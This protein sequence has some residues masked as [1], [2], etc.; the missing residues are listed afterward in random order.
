MRDRQPR[1][2][3]RLIAKLGK[4]VLIAAAVAIA[5]G[6]ALIVSALV[7]LQT[8]V[9]RRYACAR[10]EELANDVLQGTMQLGRCSALG[11]RQLRIDG[12]SMHD[13]TGRQVLEV[14]TV[15]AT[16][17]LKALLR[18]EL[19]ID[20]AHLDA[21]TLRL[22]G[23][24]EAELGIT[25]AFSPVA[26]VEP[27]E[28]RGSTS[29]GV[30]VES[31]EVKD[32]SA[33]GLPGGLIARDVDGIAALAL[34]DSFTLTIQ[35]LSGRIADDEGRS[36]HLVGAAG[37]LR[38]DKDVRSELSL[39]LETSDSGRVAA[40]GDYAQ[41]ALAAEVEVSDV[42]IASVPVLGRSR[43]TL[44]GRLEVLAAF[45]A[46][47]SDPG[48]LDTID[49]FAAFEARQLS[50]QGLEARVVRLGAEVQGALPSPRVRV[51]LAAEGVEA[52]DARFERMNLEATGRGGRYRVE[53]RVPFANGVFADLELTTRINPKLWLVDG[54]VRMRGAAVSPLVA[55]L[56][57]IKLR[58]REGRAAG[59]VV[60][61]GRGIHMQARGRYDAGSESRLRAVVREL[62]LAELGPALGLDPSLQGT[63]TGTLHFRG[64]LDQPKLDAQL[65]LSDGALGS[66][67]PA[68]C[69]FEATLQ[70]D[71]LQANL[72]L[73]LPA[74][75]ST[76][77]SAEV[78]DVS[79]RARLDD[80]THLEVRAGHGESPTRET[81]R[82]TADFAAPWVAWVR[83]GL[84]RD[85]PSMRIEGDVTDLKL[86][87]LPG[88]CDRF[89]GHVNAT[90]RGSEVFTSSQELGATF[91]V[92]DL[93]VLG[94]V[95][96]IEARGRLVA[97]ATE[98]NATAI[99]ESASRV[100]AGIEAKVPLRTPGGGRSIGWGSGDLALRVD[101][102]DAPLAVLLGPVPGVANPSGRVSGALI[103]SGPADD[104]KALHVDAELQLI[105][106]SLTVENPFLRLDDLDGV[107]ALRDDALVFES[108]SAEDLG[109]R[110]KL[111]GTIALS[112]W[113]PRDVRLH[114]E[115][116]GYP[117]RRDGIVLAKLNGTVEARGDLGQRPR[118]LQ[119]TFERDVSLE[120]PEDIRRDI[121]EL[122]RHP[123]VI[124]E[125]EPGFDR[126][127][128][129]REAL[130]AHRS[131]D[132]KGASADTTVTVK[133][134]SSEP[135]W[136]RRPDFSAQLSVDVQVRDEEERTWVQ[137]E[138]AVRRGFI[139]LLTK[140]FDIEQGSIRFTGATPIDPVVDLTAVHRLSSGDTVT[141]RIEGRV[142]AP[143]LSFTTTAA[144][145]NTDA[146][147]I[148]LLLGV[149][150]ST[151]DEQDARAQTG[152]I[153]A[154][155][156]AGLVGT[157]A[158]RE[159]GQYA[160]IIALQSEGTADTTN[161]RIG[162]T[163]DPLVPDALQDVVLGVY[164]EGIVGG[165][166]QTRATAGFLVELLFPH[167]LSTIATYEQPDNWSLDILWEP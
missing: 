87:S 16:V 155:V 121:Q 70:D 6:L 145:A 1:G 108:F 84:P 43:G 82:L 95:E 91:E 14:E 143:E 48:S 138:I 37:V 4:S 156:T 125:G 31:L 141:I 71:A 166:Q 126:S 60:V 86:E 154:G 78:F 104:V 39:V 58:L 131:K 123:Q 12:F 62:D 33:T 79:A 3:V 135:F 119:V 24:E 96:P 115:A 47:I 98:A 2:T 158:R 152:A 160:P 51:S 113:K 57:R 81:V 49:L 103:A 35:R 42:E 15:Q 74:S 30:F 45:T 114:I 148:A 56:K 61:R 128:G 5:L 13:P 127:L 44:D 52:E 161:V 17:V 64:S 132:G 90:V 27:K 7:A 21:P 120:L 149:R 162:T 144:G 22:V 46:G 85:L 55:E 137:G 130:E 147:I 163:L 19:R 105:G 159:L 36:A 101:V 69:D 97:D 117:L 83:D 111:D 107:V 110:V 53:G 150:R 67:R 134:R 73:L 20:E 63:V 28:A 65:S 34:A 25:R 72:A 66:F 142:S 157:V 167:Y 133:A 40:E 146:Q 165:S 23:L 129:V 106:A 75:S 94:S 100:I 122:G 112:Q 50:Y 153:L 99:L 151:N 116:D 80:R 93:R 140:S 29:F 32:G 89:R 26:S 9:G 10:I 77:P 76:C 109:G 38:F 102:R 139:V 8:D 164:V 41:G 88:A 118:L 68:R 18:A 124:Y 136:V 11:P 59:S 92:E 54:T